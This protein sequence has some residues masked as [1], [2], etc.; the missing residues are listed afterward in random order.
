VLD[1]AARDVDE[2]DLVIGAFGSITISMKGHTLIAMPEVNE[3][4]DDE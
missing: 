1:A 4:D 3:E 2:L